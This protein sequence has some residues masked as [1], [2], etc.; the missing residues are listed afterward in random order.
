MATAVALSLGVFPW[1]AFRKTVPKSQRQ[2][3]VNKRE[4]AK[5]KCEG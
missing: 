1:G 3:V 2:D 5:R 4:N